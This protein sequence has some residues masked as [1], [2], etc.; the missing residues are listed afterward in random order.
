M[1]AKTNKP[2]KR[3]TANRAGAEKSG[4]QGGKCINVTSID[5]KADET[6]TLT[7]GN[8][9]E[10]SALYLIKGSPGKG[11]G[12]F[13]VKDIPKGTRILAETPFFTLAKS[14]KLF[15]SDPNTSN[16]IS[17]AFERLPAGEQIKYMGLHCP[18]RTDCS[19]L[20]SIYEANCYEMGSGSC[21]CLDAARI[22]HSCVPNAH[23]SWND[24]TKC[25]TV[26]AIKDTFKGEEITISY[27]SA[28]QTLQERK[29]KLKPYVFTCHCPAC[30][31]GT[32]FGSMSQVRHQQ[33]LDLDQQIADYQHDLPTARAVYGHYDEHSAT[34][35]I[36]GLLDKEG[37]FYEKSLAYHDA[38]QWALKRGLKMEALEYA[39]KQLNVDLCCVGH[40][41]PFYEATRSFFLGIYLGTDRV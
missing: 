2:K 10:A 29:R 20:I 33:M 17:Q 13:A 28:I 40:D 9:V 39:S 12:M 32:V 37:L 30:Q 14:P 24:S 4:R 36:L 41:S 1:T 25:I 27:C 16:D 21:I 8:N 6:L 5:T 34:Q 23:Y 19:I 22:N 35:E 18:K 38:A 3:K 31:D 7:K 15:W 26:H 11:L